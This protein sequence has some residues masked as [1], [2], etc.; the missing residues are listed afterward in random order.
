LTVSSCEAV[1]ATVRPTEKVS[2]VS[3]QR[4]NAFIGLGGWKVST[5][6]ELH[7]RRAVCRELCMQVCNEVM[8]ANY[9]TAQ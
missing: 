8:W 9:C 1:I 3:I 5:D 7:D 6:A 4:P 2:K